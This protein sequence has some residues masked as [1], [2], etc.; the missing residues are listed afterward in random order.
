MDLIEYHAP[1][2]HFCRSSAYEYVQSPQKEEYE[3]P[4]FV[5]ITD[6]THPVITFVLNASGEQ[7]EAFGYLNK[8]MQHY[9]IKFCNSNSRECEDTEALQGAL[10]FA[11]Q[12]L[13]IA[14]QHISMED[15]HLSMEDQHLSM[16]DQHPDMK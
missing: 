11:S 12:R 7:L 8:W 5:D 6:Y 14:D 1:W 4:S 3:A 13:S 15:Q 10:Q 9:G 16:E 2:R